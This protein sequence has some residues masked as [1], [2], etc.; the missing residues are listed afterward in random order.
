M[1]VLSLEQILGQLN[2]VQRR[3]DGYEAACPVCGSDHHL[4]VHQK[5]NKVLMYCQRCNAKMPEILKHLTMPP[6]DYTPPPKKTYKPKPKKEI[7]EKIT[8]T[9]R[10][11]DGTIAYWKKREKYVDGSKSFS[12]A[13]KDN[14]KSVYKKPPDSINMYNLDK[15]QQADPKTTLYI[16]EG[17]KCANAMAANGFL[18]T[19]TCTGAQKNPALTAADLAMLNK[20]PNKVMLPDNDEK[21]MEYAE[22][23]ANKGARILPMT[24]IWPECPEKGDVADFFE[25]GGDAEFIRNYKF[26]TAELS[27]EY[28]EGLDRYGIISPDL[29]RQID[30]IKDPEKRAHTESMAAFRAR[31]LGCAREYARNYKAFRIHRAQDAVQSK[32][33]TQ[34]PGQPFALNCGKWMTGETG[35]FEPVVNALG[36]S[37]VVVTSH[38]PIMPTEILVNMEDGTEKIRLSFFKGGRWQS[39][40]VARAK[41]ANANKIIELA[42]A[43]IEVNS[44]NSKRLVKYIAECVALNPEILPRTKSVSHMGWNE[45]GFIPYMDGIKLDCEEEYWRLVNSVDSKGSL[46][47]WLNLVQPLMKNLYLRFTV[48]ASL[49]SVLIEKVGALPF[50]LHLWGGTGAGKTVGLMVAASVWGNPRL[51]HLVRTM[52]M[53]INSMMATAAVL[54]NIPFFGDELQTIKSRYENYDTLIMRVCE[55]IDR[56]RMNSGAQMQKQATWNNAFIFT[57]E[58]PCT[59]TNSGGGVK[60]RVIEMECV[61]KVV[62]EGNQ[63]VNALN[64]CYGTLGPEFL[65]ALEGIDLQERYGFWMRYLLQWDTTEKQA[66]AMA[67]IYMADEILRTKFMPGLPML[68]DE[69]VQFMKKK[70]EIDTAERAYQ[71]TLDLIAENQENFDMYSRESTPKIIWGEIQGDSVWFNRSVLE[72]ELNRMGFSFK[73]IRLKWKRSGKLIPAEDGKFTVSRSIC[74]IKTRYVNLLI[75]SAD[76][77]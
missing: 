65:K 70:T 50:V 45:E 52:N 6:K 77:K 61:S 13:Y 56:G 62:N 39:I 34:F 33:M 48:D 47:D 28:F 58:E 3:G 68:T 44:D 1:S 4:Y 21:G 38:I 73:A 63:I 2:N 67:L 72:R 53:T 74:G 49:A 14:G 57:G 43:G 25:R 37:D 54:R 60:N 26:Q 22:G 29:F 8:Y 31:E 5:G 18:C 27:K 71:M 41:V 51:G 24:E 69:G 10:N 42:D 59:Q 64:T 16:V 76:E 30:N 7:I 11:P 15:L 12:F 23:W 19:T 9:Y 66:M 55:G 35:V 32:N 75:K 36:D 17:E 46:T 20:F 40:V